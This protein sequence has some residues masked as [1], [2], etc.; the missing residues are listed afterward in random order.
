MP[1]KD[2]CF[3]TCRGFEKPECNPPRCKYVNG[4]KLKYC[5]LSQR[6]KMNKP[7]CNVTRKLKK[8][9][10]KKNATTKIGEV[11]KKSKLFLNITCPN[12]GVCVSFGKNISKIN[13]FFKGFTDFKYA[14]SPIKQIGATSANG[15]VKEISYEKQGYKADAILK[16]SQ[17]EDAD[18]LVYEYVVGIKYINRIMRTFP[19]FLETY[20]LYFYPDEMN[21]KTMSSSSPL[22]TVYLQ[23][24][25]LQSSIDYGKACQESKYASILIQHIKSAKTLSRYTSVSQYNRFIKN[26]LLYV[27]FI[28]Y[29]C[30]SS[31]S[32]TFTHYDLH[33]DN[34]LLYEPEHGKYIQ[35]IYHN[36]DGTENVFYSPY[37]PKIID[38][39][40]SFFDNG[41]VNSRKIYEKICSVKECDPDCG[42]ESGFNWLNPIPEYMI[43]SSQKNESHDLRLL[44]MIKTDLNDIFNIHHSKLNNET[45]IELDKI[46]NKVVYGVQLKKEY[47][48]FGTVENLE[49]S[50]DK[51]KNVNGA[52]LA[53]KDAIQNPKVI[54][55]NQMNYNKFSNLL[56]VLHVYHDGRPVKYEE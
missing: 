13:D 17:R 30:L 49:I 35:Y 38:Y 29:Q 3:S 16:S 6:Y 40:R 23:R 18:N 41:N 45:F 47:K 37:I 20:G 8:D 14:V 44:N 51:I 19:C 33:L 46:A 21:W 4:S 24:L 56:G 26:D 39:G 12:S 15:F 32:T 50:K 27:L 55:E 31:I 42:A 36:K 5:K 11:I 28:I 43:S 48:M 34:I 1:A 52:Y 53:L 2:K 25:K 10:I 54:A 7:K 22:H 9:E